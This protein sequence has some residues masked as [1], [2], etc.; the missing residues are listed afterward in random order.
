LRTLGHVRAFRAAEDGDIEGGVDGVEGSI[1]G[2]VNL[3]EQTMWTDMTWFLQKIPWA[4]G[5]RG[6]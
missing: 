3:Q 1:E 4:A 6:P 5:I 2:S